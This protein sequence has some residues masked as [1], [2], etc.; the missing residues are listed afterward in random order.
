MS[1][2]PKIM[3]SNDSD[4]YPFE[5][6]TLEQIVSGD[7]KPMMPAPNFSF[8][9]CAASNNWR[10]IESELD[11]ADADPV[12]HKSVRTAEELMRNGVEF[13]IKLTNNPKAKDEN[14]VLVLTGFKYAPIVCVTKVVKNGEWYR[15]VAKNEFVF[16]VLE[17]LPV[18]SYKNEQMG[19]LKGNMNKYTPWTRTG[20]KRVPVVPSVQPLDYDSQRQPAGP[21][22]M[23]PTGYPQTYQSTE[24]P[25]PMHHDYYY[26]NANMTWNYRF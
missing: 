5:S 9:W 24:A 20:K 8:K 2:A 13:S 7:G 11:E 6:L 19:K 22:T 3:L 18:T 15:K 14:T 10:E 4:Y 17:F 23:D 16:K 12:V 21:W 25:Q 26:P 1:I